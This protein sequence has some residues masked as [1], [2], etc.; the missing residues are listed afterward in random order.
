MRTRLIRRA[1]E[2]LSI[3]AIGACSAGGGGESSTGSGASSGVGGGSS[4]TTGAGGFGFGTGGSAPIIPDCDVCEDFPAAPIVEAGAPADAAAKFGEPGSG[5][6]TGDPCLYEPQVGAL[7]PNNWLRPRFRWTGN[8]S[9][10][11][12]RV[13]A[14]REKNDLVVYTTKTEWVMPKEMWA[15]L[16]AHVQDEPITVTLRALSGSG[17][18]VGTQGDITIAPVQAGGS[19]VY[20]ASTSI[21]PGLTTSS[22]VGFRVGDEGVVT[23][24]QPGDVQAQV[25]GDSPQL[26]GPEFGAQEGQVRCVGCHT[27]TPDGAAVAFTNHWPWNVTVA[28]IEEQTK[29]TK[30]PYL[31]QAGEMALQLPWMGVSTFSKAD[32]A[33]G[34]RRLVTSFA[35]RPISTDPGTSWKLWSYSVCDGSVSTCNVTGADELAWFDLSAPGMVPT[36]NPTEMVTALAMLRGSGWDI[37]PREGDARGAVTPD[38][39]HDGTKVVYTSTDSTEDGHIGKMAKTVDVYTVPF[40]GGSAT[41]VAGAS[42]PAHA[43]YYPDYSA[44]D[45][46][47][48]FTRIDNG[49]GWIFYRPEAEVWVVPASGGTAI[50]HAANDPA[51]CLNQQ[52]PGLLN[53]WPKWSPGVEAANGKKY[54]W[55]VFSSARN[56]GETVRPEIPANKYSPAERRS[57]QLY[58]AAVVVDAAGNTTTFPAVYL[59]NQ[60]ATTNNLTPAWDEF[61]IPPVVVE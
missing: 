1:S 28:N 53:S 10:Y 4:G 27:S 37:I 45:Q 49:T 19:L 7:F 48:A 6:A 59:W 11:E 20:W 43:E 60:D 42:D 61:K 34:K 25:Y 35:P 21:D 24:L 38:W 8:A 9:L 46:L 23:A 51:Q 12:L 13:H 5:A 22:L 39:S 33:T 32:W 52:S 40:S 41:P 36:D 50:R 57:S 16:A 3:A 47:L 58:M 30:P 15:N 44:D 55:L 54:Y 2:L 18:T 17:V 29:G 14:Q 56:L 26:T 31:T